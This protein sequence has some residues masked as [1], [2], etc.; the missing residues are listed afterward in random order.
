MAVLERISENTIQTVHNL[1]DSAAA[2]SF[3][4]FVFSIA[5]ICCIRGIVSGLF[6]MHR[7]RSAVK[8]ANKAHSF[9]QKVC[10]KHAWVDCL[11]A[12]RFCRFLI[13]IHHCIFGFLL[14]EL[15]LAILSNV[16]PGVMPTIAW[17]TVIYIVFVSIPV[18]LLNFVLDR[19]PFRKFKHEFRFKQYH[20]TNDHDSLW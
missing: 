12:K 20:N 10:L 16:W 2:C 1:S 15:F 9:W 5:A 6:E 18:C 11:H 7:S 13:I 17:F 8:K 19:Y 4:V 3:L 14:A